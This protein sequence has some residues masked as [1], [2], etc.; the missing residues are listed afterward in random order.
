M[1]LGI[2]TGCVGVVAADTNLFITFTADSC[3]VVCGDGIRHVVAG[4]EC[5]DGNLIDG[6]GCSRHCSIEAG[7]TCPT[8]GWPS[9]LLTP[10]VPICGDGLRV[11]DEVVGSLL[12]TDCDYNNTEPGDGCSP[13]CEVEIGWF[14]KRAGTGVGFEARALASSSRTTG[15]PTASSSLDGDALGPARIG[16]QKMAM[17]ASSDL[18]LP[19]LAKPGKEW[20]GQAASSREGPAARRYHFHRLRIFE[21]M[22]AKAASPTIADKDGSGYDMAKAAQK[23]VNGLRRAEARRRKGA[24]EKESQEQKWN[25]FQAEM[26]QNC[27]A[28][29]AKY[30]DRIKKNKDEAEEM[31]FL[32]EVPGAKEAETESNGTSQTW[33]GRKRKEMLALIARTPIKE[34]GKSTATVPTGTT[35]LAQKLEERKASAVNVA[36]D[37][38][39]EAIAELSAAKRK[40]PTTGPDV[41]SL[42][43]T[44]SKRAAR[45]LGFFGLSRTPAMASFYELEFPAEYIEYMQ[46]LF[47]FVCGINDWVCARATPGDIFHVQ[48]WAFGKIL[49]YDCLS[50]R[51]QASGNSIRLACLAAFVHGGQV[52]GCGKGQW[53]SK[54]KEEDG[55]QPGPTSSWT[56]DL[57]IWAAGHRLVDGRPQINGLERGTFAFYLSSP[58]TRDAVLKQFGYELED[59]VDVLVGA[60]WNPETDH[61]S[62]ID[63]RNVEFQTEGESGLHERQRY[64]TMGPLAVTCDLFSLS[65]DRTWW[66]APTE[67]SLRLYNAGRRTHSVIAAGAQPRATTNVVMMDLS[68][69]PAALWIQW[70]A[71]E[72]DALH[73]GPGDLEVHLQPTEDISPTE[74]IVPTEQCGVAARAGLRGKFKHVEDQLDGLGIQ[75]V[76]LQ[77]LVKDENRSFRALGRKKRRQPESAAYT[78]AVPEQRNGPLHELAEEKWHGV[79]KQV[80]QD[81]CDFLFQIVEVD[82]EVPIQF[83]IDSILSKHPAHPDEVV[84]V[85]D[86]LAPHAEDM[87]MWT[88]SGLGKILAVLE[89]S[90]QGQWTVARPEEAAARHA[91][92]FQSF[93]AL[94][95]ELRS[96]WTAILVGGS[97]SGMGKQWQR[98]KTDSWQ[99][100][101]GKEYGQHQ[102]KYWAGSWSV[103]PRAPKQEV[104]Q[105]Y[106]QVKIDDARQSGLAHDQRPWRTPQAE[107]TGQ[108]ATMNAIQKALTTARKAD[109]RIRKLMDDKARKQKQW[110]RWVQDQRANYAKQ[111]RQFQHDLEKIDVE[112]A[113]AEDIGTN[114]AAKVKDVILR[115][116]E[117]LETDEGTIETEARE[118]E[119]LMSEAMSLEPA[120]F[121]QE[122]YL[123]AQ[124]LQHRLVALYHNS[125]SRE[126]LVHF[127]MGI[128]PTE[129]VELMASSLSPQ[130]PRDP[131]SPASL[132]LMRGE[133]AE[134]SVL[135]YGKYGRMLPPYCAASIQRPITAKQGDMIQ[136][137]G[138]GA[139]IPP[140]LALDDLLFAGEDGTGLD[141]D[142]AFHRYL[143]S[144]TVATGILLEPR[145]F[146]AFHIEDG[147]S[148]ESDSDAPHIA[149]SVGIRSSALRVISTRPRV[150]NAAID[151]LPCL[152]LGW[153]AQP[154]PGGQFSC[155]DCLDGI[156]QELGSGWRLWFRDVP[157]QADIL[158]VRTGQ[159]FVVEIIYERP[160]SRLGNLANA[161]PSDAVESSA[162]A[163]PPVSGAP[164][165][166]AD[167][168]GVVTGQAGYRAND[169]GPSQPS[170]ISADAHDITN[171][172]G[173]GQRQ[174]LLAGLDEQADYEVLQT[175]PPDLLAGEVRRTFVEGTFA[176][177]VM[178][179]NCILTQ[180]L[181]DDNLCF[182]PDNW[183]LSFFIGSVIGYGGGPVRREEDIGS[184]GGNWILPAALPEGLDSWWRKFV[185]DLHGYAGDL[186]VV[187]LGDLNLRLSESW[188]DRIGD[189]CWE[190][191][192]SPPEP[193]FKMM[194]N[195]GLW[196]PST[197]T[198]CHRGLSHTWVSPGQG[199]SSRIDFVLVPTTWNVDHGSSRV[200]YEVDFGQ[201]GLDHF[202]VYLEISAILDVSCYKGRRPPRIDVSRLHEPA[203]ANIVQA[204]C[205]T[206]PVVPWDVDAHTHY[207][208]FSRHLV[209]HLALA[210]PTGQASKRKSFFS[211]CT[212]SFRQ[213]RVS[214]RK[215]AHRASA[216]IANYEVRIAWVAW[217]CAGPMS[218][219]G[220]L[221][222]ADLLRSVADLSR[223][224]GDL[225]RL[226]PLLRRSIQGDKRSFTQE[227]ARAAGTC[228]SKDTFR[229][230]RTLIG[231]PKR[232]VKGSRA[233]PAVKLEDGSIAT[234]LETAEARWIRHFSSI[235]AGA[236]ETPESIV[237]SCF[238]RQQEWDLADYDVGAEEILTRAQIEDGLRA[239]TPGKAAG[240]DRVP[241]DLL[242]ACPSGLSR[243]L[244]PIVLKF[245]MRLQEPVQWKG[246]DLH[247]V[248]TRKGSP[249]DCESYRAILVSSSVGKAVHGALRT[250]C[251]RHFEN[252]AMP[253]Q[254]GGRAGFPVQFVLQAARL[255]QERCRAKK[256]S[257]AVIFLDLKEAF[258]RVARALV[259]GGRPDETSIKNVIATLGLAAEVGPRL[260]AYVREQSLIRS[261][262]GP[263]VLSS[264]VEESNCDTWFAHGALE[265]TAI[266]KAGTRPGDN[267]ADLIFSFLF[268][269][270]LAVLRKRFSETGLSSALPWNEA[271]LRAGPAASAES[272]PADVVRPVDA[273]WMDDLALLI[274]DPHPDKL[275]DKVVEVAT[276]TLDECMKA[277]LV[278]NLTEGKTECVL[279]LCG[280]GSKKLA[281]QVFRGSS[282]DLPLQSDIWPE[283]R[284]RLV[285][286]YKHVG[287]LVQAGGGTA[288]EVRS[289]IGA[290]WAAFRQHRRQVFSSPLVQTRDKAVLFSSVVESTLFYGVGAWP[291]H[292]EAAT[293]K[294]Q[295]ALIGMARLM[296]RP[297]FSYAQARHLSGLYALA[298]ARTMPA[299][300]TIALER[301]RHFRLV[302]SKGCAEFWALL[303]AEQS[304]LQQAQQALTWAS[305]LR[306]RAGLKGPDLSEWDTAADI[307]RHDAGRWKGL[308]KQTKI[309]AGLES[310]W[311]AEVQQYHGLLFRHLRLA[312]AYLDDVVADVIE[313]ELCALCGQVFSDKRAWS[314]HAFKVHGRVREERL[315]VTGQQC[316]VCLRHY[317]ST[318]KL[319]NHLRYSTECK[320]ALIGAGVAV[321]PV[322]GVGSRK[323]V[324]GSKSQLPAVQ[325]QGPACQWRRDQLPF[326]EHRPS[327]EV[328]AALEDCFCNDCGV[329]HTYSALLEAYRKAFSCCCLQLSRLRVT[330]QEWQ[331]KLHETLTVDEE[332]SVRWSG[333]HTS[334]TDLIQRVSWADWLV[335]DPISPRFAVSTF[336]DASTQLPWLLYEHVR[337]DL[338]DTS[339]HVGQVIADKD[340]G[341]GTFLSHKD[342]A[343]LPESL[344]V[345]RFPPPLG[346]RLRHLRL[347]QKA[348]RLGPA[349]EE[350]DDGNNLAG[351][352]CDP[353]CQV[354]VGWRT[355]VQANSSKLLLESICGDGLVVGSE[356]C[357]D[358]NLDAGDGCSTTCNTEP[359]FVCTPEDAMTKPEA[360]AG[361]PFAAQNRSICVPVCGDGVVLV[362]NGEECDDGNRVPNDGCDENCRVES[363]Y[364]CGI[365]SGGA[366]SL[367]RSACA[368]VC[369]DGLLRAPEECDDGND[370]K[371]DGCDQHCKLEEGYRC[372]PPGAAC[373]QLCGDYLR[374][375][376]EECDDGNLLLAD[377]CDSSCHVEVGWTCRS[378]VY[379]PT[380]ATSLCSPICGD[381]M[382]HGA[383]APHMRDLSLLSASRMA[384]VLT[385][386]HV[387]AAGHVIAQ[388]DCTCALLTS[389]GD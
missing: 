34:V 179:S 53:P 207:E 155:R 149:N 330:A 192:A 344:N 46:Q 387:L 44:M 230:L 24:E 365:Q 289:R 101:R 378:Y 26:K 91:K 87:L 262:G 264:M 308:V 241:A 267:L 127:P 213:Q 58:I 295:G 4:E 122:A 68:L 216:W 357:D 25:N 92:T 288:K 200:L 66:R 231:P 197:F 307:A 85:I 144:P 95:Q 165:A 201:A 22:E 388:A 373:R 208:L 349:A 287:G 47:W 237:A 313:P 314:H 220:L 112:L 184:L 156:L 374:L 3:N 152:F 382:I 124:Q 385:G 48:E 173:L 238:A 379:G 180:R 151:G 59:E 70:I 298:C 37:S 161:L 50:F 96:G 211:D 263:A 77:A 368:P 203:N 108:L 375:E 18:L 109:G 182:T 42:P 56:A 175:S 333:W 312:G 247:A 297:R 352:G 57:E 270:L 142:G 166:P 117:A 328:L 274:E 55:D 81:I 150:W 363:G 43:M 383:E 191:G 63:E 36:D 84:A 62:H 30:Q 130:G 196:A 273:T 89:R 134:V 322:P 358:G 169:Y 239:S 198:A 340:P 341:F 123:A 248:W 215:I 305:E 10:C 32:T 86:L 244:Y 110:E 276:A 131:R 31:E 228:S 82:D 217:S 99:P 11:G 364:A 162:G 100:G 214:L 301:L 360:A 209:E 280:P 266:V 384:F 269:E 376:G 94:I 377:G 121:Y 345:D 120:G 51:W 257:C 181:L 8:Q 178:W 13:T 21:D 145:P 38:E 320:S 5:D 74:D 226:K 351:D 39:D 331:R 76:M 380:N 343:D 111:K 52:L 174:D 98:S 15:V 16:Q 243:S 229:K 386:D 190:E 125:A 323:F 118:W 318:E 105:N 107:P 193:F 317:R 67:R 285:S 153:R 159:V 282:P 204:I 160:V 176:S 324:D 185:D 369:G 129:V 113:Q 321:A 335:P 90:N 136:V 186:P 75:L 114:A 325:A 294:F 28:E 205:K 316:P 234:D 72:G 170:R 49:N 154:A 361:P 163:D 372:W 88:P 212:W 140:V 33:T 195:H 218:W 202:A 143:L 224:V 353:V 128:I 9:V 35:P 278:P 236:P 250:Q 281:T 251:G 1:R 188:A 189:L 219:A 370:G 253:L 23:A 80:Y 272:G 104:P 194:L 356:G 389:T 73:P 141:I 319:C 355:K 275:L 283:A 183:S 300:L 132:L 277:T 69:S 290:A 327:T 291:A 329:C 227:A 103:S 326:E 210:F 261:A 158:E 61:P 306:T 245:A 260:Q 60:R 171:V 371:G 2:E 221:S 167:T 332:W 366:S 119:S 7:F 172:I 64:R 347:V 65:P 17:V 302:V 157:L 223:S 138:Y 27:V 225:R 254:V 242:R 168:A 235:E 102:Y 256:V 41:A 284:L 12:L 97:C 350:C 147:D 279:A 286:T 334:V 362:G 6:D 164:D 116:P 265:G 29:Q 78:L 381:G 354:E 338:P 106:D 135:S 271:W 292:N 342:A 310:L 268:A 148:S 315:L 336:K 177:I 133:L 258:H 83:E 222:L 54:G 259:H 40:E 71:V 246:G 93:L 309:A 337:F 79:E 359:G 252:A 367:T 255:W 199:T 339:G 45:L 14:C 20:R 348:A 146:R 240:K 249:L 311:T 303:H 126:A 137:I 233:I 187:V 293:G 304:W 115:G 139:A 19:G 296:L 206:V 299:E 232:K 346:S